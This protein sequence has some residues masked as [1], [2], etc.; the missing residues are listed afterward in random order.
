MLQLSTHL[1]GQWMPSNSSLKGK[2][3]FLPL[4]LPPQLL[5]S[6]LLLRA[7][8]VLRS[9]ALSTH[10][11]TGTVRGK[12]CR[13]VNNLSAKGTRLEAWSF[14]EMF[15]N[16]FSQ[17]ATKKFVASDGSQC[18]PAIDSSR[19]GAQKH[20]REGPSPNQPAWA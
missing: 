2:Q 9:A 17:Q 5:R 1:G 12:D 13:K 8:L 7:L 4:F 3:P 10:K 6:L 11:C 15:I 19:C 14:Q 20:R 16:R 18:I